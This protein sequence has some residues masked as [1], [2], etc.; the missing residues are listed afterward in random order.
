MPDINTLIKAYPKHL[1]ELR[2]GSIECGN[3]WFS[4]LDDLLGTVVEL[5]RRTGEP[6]DFAP[7]CIKEKFGVLNI[8]GYTGPML[9]RPLVRDAEDLSAKVCEDCGSTDAVFTRASPYWI[10]TLCGVC[11]ESYKKE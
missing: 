6:T 5:E 4:I 8:Q 2:F 11:R 3:G 7:A 9:L 1:A 10:R